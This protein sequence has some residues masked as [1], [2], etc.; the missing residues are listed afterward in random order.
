MKNLLSA[1]FFFAFFFFLFA[2]F[3]WYFSLHYKLKNGGKNTSKRP[4]YTSTKSE[5]ARDKNKQFTSMTQNFQTR[6]PPNSTFPL[7][8]LHQSHL[9][10]LVIKVLRV[11]GKHLSQLGL[12]Y[13]LEKSLWLS[14]HSLLVHFQISG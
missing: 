5:A 9:G 7:R 10:I 4:Q 11:A 1:S 8:T 14:H 2:F 12:W 13:S 6:F 3:F